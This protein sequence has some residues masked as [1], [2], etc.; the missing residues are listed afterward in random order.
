M[1]AVGKRVSLPNRS[2]ETV[3]QPRK[4]SYWP[5]GRSHLG[6][7]PFLLSEPPILGTKGRTPL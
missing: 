2:E 7:V 1:E 4:M 3:F 6:A 5:L